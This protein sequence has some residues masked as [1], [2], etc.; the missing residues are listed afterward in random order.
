MT[1]DEPAFRAAV[2]DTLARWPAARSSSRS[3]RRSDRD[4]G[5][6]SENR[7]AALVDFEI[8][9]DID[10]PPTRSIRSS[11]RRRGPG[12]PSRLF[13][14]EFGDAS[15]T[16]S[17]T[18]RSERPREGR[19]ALAADHADHPAITFGALVAAG[20]PLLLALTAVF[21]TFGLM[22]LISHFLPMDQRS[23]RWCC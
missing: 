9:G 4:A 23:R 1:I 16:R 20:I 5:Q 21:A 7:H 18:R 19:D 22:A 2:D 10:M 17:S 13:I 6:V 8:N 14:G 12:R 11:R 15:A 3:A